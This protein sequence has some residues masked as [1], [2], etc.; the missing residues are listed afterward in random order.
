ML[1]RLWNQ[2]RRKICPKR[3]YVYG[4][5]GLFIRDDRTVLEK[6]CD[7]ID[8]YFYQKRQEASQSRSKATRVWKENWIDGLGNSHEVI[9]AHEKKGYAYASQREW[10]QTASNAKRRMDKELTQRIHKKVEFVTS[11]VKKGRKYNTKESF[12]SALKRVNG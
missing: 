2:F 9:K 11:E 1:E 5:Q 4:T 6:A 3:L 7:W 12:Q 8:E 10:E